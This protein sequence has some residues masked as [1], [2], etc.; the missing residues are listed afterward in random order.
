MEEM[1]DGITAKVTILKWE[2]S[3]KKVQNKAEKLK[4]DQEGEENRRTNNLYRC[5]PY[6]NKNK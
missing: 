2:K 5:L 4:G 3:S 6:K 1:K